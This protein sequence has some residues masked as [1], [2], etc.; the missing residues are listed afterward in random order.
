MNIKRIVMKQ[1]LCVFFVLV[2]SCMA[3]AQS[4]TDYLGTWRYEKGDT[5]FTIRLI[6]GKTI[7]EEGEKMIYERM[8]ILFGGYSLVVKGKEITNCISKINSTWFIANGGVGAKQNVYIK[9]TYFLNAPSCLGFRFYDQKMNHFD[10]WGISGGAIDFIAPDKLHWALDEKEGIWLETEGDDDNGT[11][12]PIGFS[13]PTD[14]V[15]I[16][17]SK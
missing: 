6:E 13:V 17:V 12:K 5:I 16:R 8:N 2:C 15:L 11:V 1:A 4:V 10:G 9:A 7:T 3:P 14:A